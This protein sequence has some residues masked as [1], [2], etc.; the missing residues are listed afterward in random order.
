MLIHEQCINTEII[1]DF[2]FF[3]VIYVWFS[4]GLLHVIVD[5]L[6]FKW[7]GVNLVERIDV[8]R[9]FKEFNHELWIFFIKIFIS[10]NINCFSITTQ[11]DLLEKTF[12]MSTLL[13]FLFTSPSQTLCYSFF[14][15]KSITSHLAHLS[16]LHLL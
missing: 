10:F 12:N 7:S 11:A 15:L 5:V 13:P 4:R 6:V 2:S 8:M 3:V 14:T 16:I 9:S 1:F